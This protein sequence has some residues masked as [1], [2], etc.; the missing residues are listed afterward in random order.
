MILLRFALLFY[1]FH[2]RGLWWS[3]IQYNICNTFKS[4]WL[5]FQNLYITTQDHWR[6]LN[7]ASLPPHLQGLSE[8]RNL[9]E[10]K[11]FFNC[12]YISPNIQH[13]FGWLSELNFCIN[14][15]RGKKYWVYYCTI[16][17]EM[18]MQPT[19]LWFMLFCFSLV[20]KSQCTLVYPIS[21]HAIFTTKS[22][23][24]VWE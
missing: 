4:C 14:L 15:V 7:P 20:I 9:H 17:C 3:E 10:N 22:T 16:D 8:F 21:L 11:M 23:W 24:V 13:I 6:V 2:I 5:D 1:T 12:F 19:F 18:T